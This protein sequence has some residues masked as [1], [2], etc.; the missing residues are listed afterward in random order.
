MRE[1]EEKEI[2]TLES[3]RRMKNPKQFESAIETDT[4]GLKEGS[5]DIKKST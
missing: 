5:I 1:E 2:V 3:L 4:Y